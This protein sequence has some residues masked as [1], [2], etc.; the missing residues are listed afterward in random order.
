MLTP[1]QIRDLTAEAIRRCPLGQ[2]SDKF[3]DSLTKFMETLASKVARLVFTKS[4]AADMLAEESFLR[5]FDF[6]TRNQFNKFIDLVWKT[7]EK[8]MI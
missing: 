8:A 7:Y 3:T 6:L 4:E 1:S 2:V 5:N